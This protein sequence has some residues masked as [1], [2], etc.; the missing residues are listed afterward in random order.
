M[1]KKTKKIRLNQ[2]WRSRERQH[3]KKWQCGTVGV[4]FGLLACGGVAAE[5]LRI[6]VLLTQT[7][8]IAYIGNEMR[9]AWNLGMSDEGWNKDGDKFA[10]VPTRVIMVDDQ[11]KTEVAV[12]AVDKMLAGDKVHI[13]TGIMLSNVAMAVAKPVMGAQ[14]ILLSANA[15]P[16]PLAGAQC[17]PYFMSVAFQSDTVAEAMGELMSK[18]GI[19]KVFLIAP[20]YQA[21]KDYL[22][23]FERTYRGGQVVDR[24]LF[25]FGQLD[26]QAEISQIRASG[27]TAVFGFVP[28]SMGI[29]FFKQWEAAGMKQ[30]VKLYTLFSVDN[31][32]LPAIGMSA[33]GTYHTNIWS[34]DST[35]PANQK[36]VQSFMAKYKREPSH[37]AAQA[38]D[39][40]HLIAAAV[41]SLN[42]KIDGNDML[43]LAKALRTAK[44][45]SVRGDFVANVNGVPIQ[46]IIKREVILDAAGKPK[47]V[48][49]GV[50]LAAHK[51]FYW[52]ECPPA[53]RLP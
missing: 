7:G 23:G 14:K 35:S 43:P 52:Q 9:D 2:Y 45:A 51:D 36:F 32:S 15:T 37:Y 34:P 19:K 4:A 26:F 40:A 28:A 53:K 33:V 25:K 24:T 39:S 47:I 50:V 21:G 6:G 49:R 30:T 11:G 18:E 22:A 41:K 48:G 10:G 3:M 20:N 8:G 16:A 29:A 5:E 44:F 42:G 38:Y 1:N 27:A 13:V 31:L 17:S 46:D 12:Q